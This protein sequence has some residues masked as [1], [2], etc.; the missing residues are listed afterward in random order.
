M[1]EE[2]CLLLVD[3][4]RNR[5]LGRRLHFRKYPKRVCW[6]LLRP[7][8]F[9]VKRDSDSDTNDDY[10]DEY[11]WGVNASQPKRVESLCGARFKGQQFVGTVEARPQCFVVGSTGVIGI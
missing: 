5:D 4:G 10:V 1:E 7:D 9:V 3:G 6:Y 2:L 8:L 11:E